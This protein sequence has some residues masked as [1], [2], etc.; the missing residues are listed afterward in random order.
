MVVEILQR[1]RRSDLTALAQI[2]LY[3]KT[4]MQCH[5]QAYIT[6]PTHVQ[7]SQKIKNKHDTDKLNA[8]SASFCSCLYVYKKMLKYHNSNFETCTII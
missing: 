1:L 3:G 2:I 4:Y 8:V 6:F 7:I 5:S